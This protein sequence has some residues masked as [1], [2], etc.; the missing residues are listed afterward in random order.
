MFLL[1]EESNRLIA[2]NKSTQNISHKLD[3]F[4]VTDPKYPE[5]T[6]GLDESY[7]RSIY[8]DRSLG[9]V[10]PIHF[11]SWSGRNNFLSYQDVVIARK[12]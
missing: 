9:I 3:G 5:A 11:G 2:E 4:S 1:N 7:I 8:A 12:I 6:V 10:E